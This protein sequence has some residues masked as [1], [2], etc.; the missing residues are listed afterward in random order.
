VGF[1]NNQQ[2]S[3]L[4]RLPAGRPGLLLFVVPSQRLGLL[5]TEVRARAVA[6]DSSV[7]AERMDGGLRV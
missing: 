6:A 4:H 7:T 3:Y 2:V 5:W 1:T